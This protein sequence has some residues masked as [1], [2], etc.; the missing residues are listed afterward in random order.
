MSEQTPSP[1]VPRGRQLQIKLDLG[2]FPVMLT[3]LLIVWL[4][5]AACQS[6]PRAANPPK[7]CPKASAEVI[8]QV[9]ALPDGSP[10]VYYIDEL[11]RDCEAREAPSQ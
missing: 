7:P 4:A 2:L 8:A 3:L 10:L 1:I 6:P 5:A 11:E 9:R